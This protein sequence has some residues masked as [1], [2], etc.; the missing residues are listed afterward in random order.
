[1]TPG[2]LVAVNTVTV[3][4]TLTV[5]TLLRGAGKPINLPLL[6]VAILLAGTLGAMA[7]FWTENK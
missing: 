2:R 7:A 5:E 3:F 1:M 6:L 4:L